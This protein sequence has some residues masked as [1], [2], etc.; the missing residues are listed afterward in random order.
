MVKKGLIAAGALL[1]IVGGFYFVGNRDISTDIFG[2]LLNTPGEPVTV[3]ME[4]SGEPVKKTLGSTGGSVGLLTFPK[5]ALID[6]QEI[7]VSEISKLDGL[8]EGWNLV[9]AYDFAP[10]GQ[11][12]AQG[13]DAN[14]DA[15][16][17]SNVYAFKIEGGR[18]VRIPLFEINNKYV[19][20]I[21][22]FSGVGLI[23]IVGVVPSVAT[24][25]EISDKA[26]ELIANS[27]ANPETGDKEIINL[28][29]V[30]F[31][32]SIKKNLI[33]AEKDDSILKSSLNEYVNWL[34]FAQLVGISDSLGDMITTAEQHIN[35]AVLN[36]TIKATDRCV[37]EDDISQLVLIGFWQS[38]A[39]SLD[40]K[41]ASLDSDDIL[42]RLQQCGRFKL[43]IDSELTLSAGELAQ[44]SRAKGEMILEMG[45]DFKYSAT[46]EMTFE[47]TEYSALYR[48]T[49]TGFNGPYPFSVNS[50]P[51]SLEVEE[52][53]QVGIE[54]KIDFT[55]IS[56][57]EPTYKCIATNSGGDTTN[58][59]LKTD[60]VD[61]FD[62]MT[63][64]HE[65]DLKKDKICYC[66]TVTDWESGAGKL[67]AQKVYTTNRNIASGGVKEKTT[68]KLELHR[69]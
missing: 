3:T 15:K 35:K 32:T 45:A 27:A 39:Q 11:Q 56:E 67:V 18:L 51:I 54:M 40:L 20:G 64:T 19:T 21:S 12:F 43:T 16:I 17:D 33:A 2:A 1:F 61:W 7:S 36:A 52:T 26:K 41:V 6:E 48:T 62:S 65:E 5:N 69:N 42:R 66:L 38:F 4:L 37:Q 60:F 68:L 59:D 22:S 14:F 10:D 29:K 44:T 30:W 53:K 31:H 23:R 47:D 34:K 24:S 46:G 55:K 63:Y 58:Y 28:F 9:E 50:L 49:C 57:V 25:D 8:P 13:V